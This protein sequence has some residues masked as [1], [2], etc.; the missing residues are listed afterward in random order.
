MY[1]VESAEETVSQ[2]DALARLYLHVYI[3]M[4]AFQCYNVI[5]VGST[6]MHVVQDFD[7]EAILKI[8][9]T[10]N[11]DYCFFNG[12]LSYSNDFQMCEYFSLK[13]VIQNKCGWLW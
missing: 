3:T 4:S 11:Y 7:F 10:L 13:F 9:F 2:R 12:T 1:R 8:K 5:K 6:T